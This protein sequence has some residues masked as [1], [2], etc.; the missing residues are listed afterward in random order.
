MSGSISVDWREGKGKKTPWGPAQFSRERAPGIVEYTTASH[1][2]IHITKERYA[3]MPE[4]YRRHK[5]WAGRY[6][7]EEDCDWCVVALAFPDDY[8][9]VI[10]TDQK[11]A[12]LEHARKIFEE[13]IKPKLEGKKR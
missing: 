4:E 6:W 2:G 10:D 9:S 12:V 11:E 5:P 7:Y 3:Q 1:G 13:W 8:F